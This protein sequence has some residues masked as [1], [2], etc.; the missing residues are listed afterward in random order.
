M[1]IQ[2]VKLTP[3]QQ[4][5][6][7]LFVRRN[8]AAWCLFEKAESGKMPAPEHLEYLRSALLSM[9]ESVTA[10]LELISE[11]AEVDD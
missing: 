4:S 9:S 3:D 8:R 11:V 7:A 10:L 5:K 2:K 1:T 6:V